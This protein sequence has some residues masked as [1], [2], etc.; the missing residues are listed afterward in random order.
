MLKKYLETSEMRFLLN[1]ARSVSRF[2]KFGPWHRVTMKPRGLHR[3]ISSI[4]T[5]KDIQNNE[6]VSDAYSGQNFS[7]DYN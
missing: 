7:A 2:V 3:E 6:F 4:N 1:Y 5:H